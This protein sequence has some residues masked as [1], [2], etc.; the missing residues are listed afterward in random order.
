MKSRVVS[1][2]VALTVVLAGGSS[3]WAQDSLQILHGKEL[4]EANCARCHAIGATGKST[5][6]DAPPFRLLHLR[7]PIE[8]LEEALAEGISTGHPDMP[9]FVADPQQ[10]GAI[11]AYI[12]SMSR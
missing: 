10:I 8:D 11:V 12:R 3:A 1:M 4:V 6:P 9:E 7:Y 2:I 5:H